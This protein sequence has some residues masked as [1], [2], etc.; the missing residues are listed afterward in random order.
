[1]NLIL[2]IFFI[3]ALAIS[4]LLINGVVCAQKIEITVYSYKTLLKTTSEQYWESLE[5]ALSNLVIVGIFSDEFETFRKIY[6]TNPCVIRNTTVFPG[7]KDIATKGNVVLIFESVKS[8][9][10]YSV[11]D[12]PFRSPY[13]AKG[14]IGL[15]ET[16]R[17]PASGYSQ[18]VSA[19]KLFFN[20]ET[21]QEEIS[22][23]RIRRIVNYI[24]LNPR[25]FYMLNQ[26]K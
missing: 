2:R 15:I 23:I 14:V 9:Q 16:R 7:P 24:E 1:M 26:K 11:L 8:V 3:H 18:V 22:D 10:E 12:Q 21:N 19:K 25:G 17:N 20:P 5:D 4:V 6:R 13:W